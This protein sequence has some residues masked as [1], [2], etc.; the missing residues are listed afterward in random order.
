MDLTYNEI[1]EF[2]NTSDYSPKKNKYTIDDFT[3]DIYNDLIHNNTDLTNRYPSFFDFIE[4]MDMF[5]KNKI[6][7]RKNALKTVINKTV[8]IDYE[9][10]FS[11]GKFTNYIFHVGGTGS[12]KTYNAIEAFMKGRGRCVYLAPLRLLAREI[13]EKLHKS[14]MNCN[15]I[16]GEER[17]IESRF[18]TSATIETIDLDKEYDIV[19]IDEAFMI[20][21]VDRGRTWCDVL[22]NIKANET[23]VITNEETLN[24]LLDLISV[25]NR[26][27]TINRYERKVPIEFTD[28]I[29]E[30]YPDKTLLVSFSRSEV[31]A[32]HKKFDNASILYGNLPPEIKIEQINKFNNG[33]SNICV[34]T[35]VIGMG[36][37]LPCEYVIF[38]DIFKFDGK[39]TR[40]L[41]STEIKQ[42]G[43]RAGRYGLSEKGY[44]TASSEIMFDY[45]KLM[46]NKV[47]TTKFAYIGMNEDIYRKLSEISNDINE[48]LNNYNKLII[49]PSVYK[50]KIKLEPID[51]YKYIYDLNR[52]IDKLNYQ[53][54]FKLLSLPIN[55]YNEDFYK[56][57]VNN[58]ILGELVTYKQNEAITFEEILNDV[59]LELIEREIKKIELYLYLN[60]NFYDFID[61]SVLSYAMEKRNVFIDF[62]KKYLED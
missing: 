13:Y 38:D 58:I 26:T 51:K 57:I 3:E 29:T 59:D 23:H 61:T 33:E 39:T 25:D 2:L 47:D 10:D 44:I 22:L 6:K 31:L 62:I 7:D 27:Y 46:Y 5:I 24:L 55:E 53:I 35:D 36:I 37:N 48:L 9:Y 40:E 15:L 42:I 4:Q 56:E 60:N 14:N 41:N 43:G 8:E 20:N 50:E 16:T 30:N 54:Q 19:V 11:G 34:C 52:N 45:I 18:H 21:N 32:N 17:I 49:I 1:L 28:C 12:G